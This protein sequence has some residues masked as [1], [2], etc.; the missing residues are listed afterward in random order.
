MEI[1]PDYPGAN[2]WYAQ[3]LKSKGALL[4]SAQLQLSELKEHPE[5]T[6]DMGVSPNRWAECAESFYEAGETLQAEKVLQEYFEN[7]ADKVKAYKMDETSPNRVLIRILITQGK[8][9]E[10][11][12]VSKKSMQSEHKVPVD[13]ELY[14]ESLILNGETQLAQK[15]L[16]KYIDE[17]QGGFVNENCIRLKQQMNKN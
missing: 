11:L 10:A 9:K 4:E 14:I 17:I 12:K 13:Y 8:Y 7:Q 5:G 1:N 15:E 2:D 16:T 6:L 3:T